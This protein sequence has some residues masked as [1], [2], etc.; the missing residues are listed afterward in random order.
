MVSATAAV[1]IEQHGDESAELKIQG[2]GFILNLPVYIFYFLYILCS[3]SF[4]LDSRSE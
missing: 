2:K 4:C 3:D 1:V